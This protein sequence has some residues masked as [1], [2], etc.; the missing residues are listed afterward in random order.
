MEANVGRLLEDLFMKESPASPPNVVIHT[1]DAYL[2]DARISN[3]GEREFNRE[4][5]LFNLK[6]AMAVVD[7]RVAGPLKT[8]TKVRLEESY[9][10]AAIA[11]AEES[12]EELS[13]EEQPDEEV[14]EEAEAKEEPKEDEPEEEAAE[15]KEEEAAEDLP[16]IAAPK[17][18]KG[19]KGTR[20]K[21]PKAA[22]AAEEEQA[23]VQ[24]VAP[25]KVVNG[26]NLKQRILPSKSGLPPI[27][28]NPLYL[29]SR[30]MFIG[31]LARLFE[32]YQKEFIDNYESMTCESIRK[33]DSDAFNLLTHQKVIRDYLYT[34][35]PYRGLV[36]FHGLGSGKTC[37]SIAVAESMKTDRQVVFM[38]PASLKM[39]YMSE[40]KK[41]GDPLY[42]KLQYW[43][44]VQTYDNPSLAKSLSQAM[45]L[46][47]DFVHKKR[48]VW[49]VNMQKHESN[50][51]A[52][53]PIEQAQVD[54]QLNEMIQNKYM[55]INYNGVNHRRLDAITNN[56]KL[57]PFDNKT[58]VIDEA[59]N[60]VSRIVNAIRSKKQKGKVSYRLYQLLMEAE[61]AKIV[62]LTGTPILNHPFELSILYNM[63]RGNIDEWT[64]YPENPL[65]ESRV[66]RMFESNKV[67]LYDIITADR[68]QVNITRNPFGFIG[69][70]A[71]EPQPE[72]AKKTKRAIVPAAPRKTKK[73]IATGGGESGKVIYD[74]AGRVS[75]MEFLKHVKKVFQD[76]NIG[77][78]RA[79]KHTAHTILPENPELF[80][81]TFI[82]VENATI[83]NDD[84]FKRRVV[85][86]TSYFRSV[87]DKLLPRFE[88]TD[89]GENYHIVEVPMSNHQ[90]T[91]YAEVRT[92]E[93]TAE[94][95]SRKNQAKNKNKGKDAADLYKNSYRI[96]SRLACNY[97][98][99]DE[100]PRPMPRRL[101]DEVNDKELENLLEEEEE[102]EEQ[103][104][105]EDLQQQQKPASD[106]DGIHR[107][108]H[109][110]IQNTLN[111][112]SERKAE[113]FTDAVLGEHSP[114]FRAI[115][116]NIL[117]E[118]NRGLHLLYSQFR[119]MEGIGI[120]SIILEANGYTQFKVQRDAGS[121]KLSPD[122]IEALNQKKRLF[123]LY[124]GTE[125]AEEKEVV[126]NI[127]NSAWNEIPS[128]I[129]ETLR[130][131][132][133]NNN[134]G[135]IIR[136]MLITSSAAEGI[137]LRCTRYVHIV[138][139]Y[140]NMVR[141][142]QVVGR[143]RRIC[144]HQDLPE[145][146]RTVK[147]FF[148]LTKFSDEQLKNPSKDINILLLDVGRLDSKKPLTTD[149]SIY[150]IASIKTKINNA[151]LDAIKSTAVDCSVYSR[152]KDDK[153]VCY[154]YGRV[155]DSTAI[156]TYPS[157]VDDIKNIEQEKLNVRNETVAGYQFV[158]I[159]GVKYGYNEETKELYDGV[160]MESVLAQGLGRENLKP[161]G[162][163]V[164][165]DEGVQIEL[166]KGAAKK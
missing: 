74:D 112:L 136:A 42:K 13:E 29:S 1:T 59:H 6:G 127:Y 99:P 66:K 80:D 122:T 116:R 44:F 149:Q 77:F 153:Y 154:G 72:A 69:S 88:K 126:R 49:L 28:I 151:F 124:T 54:E 97:T 8:S 130:Q 19:T 152:T 159:K 7:R 43:E 20:A 32:P 119:T 144:S 73:N 101:T 63:I 11:E 40:L 134:M 82:D 30:K 123:V 120:M 52:L 76:N 140:W 62:L 51:D 41:C 60:L 155:V 2:V 103:E 156:A 150:E 55:S 133:D 147:V 36:L 107:E 9:P 137:N 45:Q 131:R 89:Q 14:K 145:E 91:K 46:S 95:K 117:N 105:Q 84:M 34:F 132:A 94:S 87:E 129:A 148:Y 17:G 92:M 35:T 139:P 165:T 142:E 27:K 104:E 64:F 25:N 78:K 138:E 96:Y 15:A 50:F 67:T 37:T 108:Y 90:F 5:L 141:I 146:L 47:E 48:G 102:E 158:N 3:D 161:I 75:N 61:N 109:V 162:K 163:L 23:L 65:D 114:K 38:T 115:L 68:T 118:D 166:Y 56:G 135:D 57:N 110:S 33:Q 22:P 121:W 85:G 98:F 100:I 106:L 157:L 39:N 26:V 31:Q 86:L 10:V 24:A 16:P 113:L 12:S 53:T 111:L 81:R 4:A 164:K 18:P 70:N 93:L 128:D 83:R 71:A 79:H 21:K 160:I 143:A 125:S 58:V